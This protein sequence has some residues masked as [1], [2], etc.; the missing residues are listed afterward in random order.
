MPPLVNELPHDV[1]KL[2]K[3]G[4]AV[5]SL[6]R[7]SGRAAGIAANVHDVGDGGSN[8]SSVSKERCWSVR[9][10]ALAPEICEPPP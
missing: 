10:Q 1:P 2:V 9:P 6:A 8:D 4:I 5:F 7:A 3:S